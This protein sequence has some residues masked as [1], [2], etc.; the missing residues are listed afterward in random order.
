MTGALF[1]Y[2]LYHKR[3]GKSRC[4]HVNDYANGQNLDFFFQ[5]EHLSY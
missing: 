4:A 1:A 5:K 2:L 3:Y